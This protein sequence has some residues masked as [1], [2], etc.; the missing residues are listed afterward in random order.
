METAT[1]RVKSQKVTEFVYGASATAG[2]Q[3]ELADEAVAVKAWGTFNG[4]PLGRPV[5]V[6]FFVEPGNELLCALGDSLKVTI[7][8]AYAVDTR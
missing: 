1:V 7:E 3:V 6:H 2:R 8:R 5:S 4:D